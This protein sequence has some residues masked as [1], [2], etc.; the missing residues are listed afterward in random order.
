MERPIVIGFFVLIAAFIAAYV[1]VRCAFSYSTAPSSLAHAAAQLH[2]TSI[3]SAGVLDA[4][5]DARDESDQ[6]SR[7]L[8]ALAPDARDV[9]GAPLILDRVHV[10]DE[11]I[12]I[13]LRSAGRDSLAN[14][15][16]DVVILLSFAKADGAWHPV[17]R[18]LIEHRGRRRNFDLMAGPPTEPSK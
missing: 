7:I 1:F 14:T 16:D 4:V 17:D 15:Q 12:A 10:I 6:R 13:E 3:L 2:Q 11:Y 18:T 5:H 8:G 9:R